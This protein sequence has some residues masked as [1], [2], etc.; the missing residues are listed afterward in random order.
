MK[1]RDAAAEEPTKGHEQVEF[2]GSHTDQLND[3]YR[4]EVAL[5]SEN[6]SGTVEFDHRGDPRW[7]WVTETSAPADP[8]AETFDHLKALDNVALSIEAPADRQ[9]PSEPPRK[10][11]YN[12]YD[13]G[14]S[15]TKPPPKR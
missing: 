5:A 9:R 6:D 13:V 2:D 14:P 7:K 12:P 8:T 1:P 10:V 4:M 11:G 15:Y 3:P